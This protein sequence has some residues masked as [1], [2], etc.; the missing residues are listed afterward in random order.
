MVF[1]L[2]IFS[3]GCIRGS[4]NRSTPLAPPG[5]GVLYD[6]RNVY[7]IETKS[8]ELV[9]VSRQ[10]HQNADPSSYLITFDQLRE[11]GTYEE[12]PAVLRCAN[13]DHFRLFQLEQRQYLFIVGVPLDQQIARIRYVLKVCLIVF[14]NRDS[15]S[16]FLG[17]QQILCYDGGIPAYKY[18]V[19]QR[20]DSHFF[21][22]CCNASYSLF[23]Y[24]SNEQ[25]K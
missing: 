19:P 13:N 4:V 7:Y 5:Q 10:I 6:F 9:A 12:I 18:V 21:H 11:G 8:A 22:S 25:G 14:H 20:L 17:S 15:L 23:D 16:G 24:W 3:L 2:L 1:M